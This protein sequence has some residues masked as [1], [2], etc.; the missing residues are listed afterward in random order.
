VCPLITKHNSSL[1]AEKEN[2]IE[3]LLHDVHSGELND[4]QKARVLRLLEA[5]GTRA[6][7]QVF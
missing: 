7:M 6:A 5:G 2:E 3:Q 4:E 1:F